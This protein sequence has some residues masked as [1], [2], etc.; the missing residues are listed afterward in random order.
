MQVGATISNV[1]ANERYVVAR[2]VLLMGAF[3]AIAAASYLGMIL[4][5]VLGAARLTPVLALTTT[6]FLT[7]ILG[8]AIV[9]LLLDRLTRAYLM[10]QSQLE[11]L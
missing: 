10:A 5:D 11:R 1:Q 3:L 6:V 4:T 2:A 9:L 8:M 7:A